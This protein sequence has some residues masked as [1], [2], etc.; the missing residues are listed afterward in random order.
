M[1]SAE[2]LQFFADLKANNNRDWFLSQKKR[3]EMVKKDQQQLVADL[4]ALLKPL[5]PS[6]EPLEVK[7]C[8]F[9]I[10]RDIRFSADKSPYKT[11]L[12]ISMSRGLKN[13]NYPGYY[14]HLDPDGSFTAGGFHSPEAADLK[15][16]RREIAFYHDDLQ[17]LL[18]EKD[19]KKI[20]GDLD[21][22]NSLKTMPKGYQKDHPAIEY[23]KLKSFTASA[24]F[25]TEEATKADFA[26]KTVKKLI[27]LKPLNDFIGR[28]LEDTDT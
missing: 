7:H 14:L 18:E 10:N 4:L 11:H 24:P 19:F 22:T 17:A 26:A 8:T 1:L 16:I 2:S 6:L 25:R 15:K 13:G 3:Y 21:R 28:A 27:A 9:R 23:L 5:D 12:G 20:Y